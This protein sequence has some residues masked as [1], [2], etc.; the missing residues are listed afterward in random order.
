VQDG[1]IK[2][3]GKK[4]L[5]KTVIRTHKKL[6]IY[7]LAHALAV[8][9]HRLTL[10]LPRYQQFEEAGQ[11]R[12]SSKSVSSQIVEGHALRQYRNE[13]LRYLARSYASAEETMEHLTFAE[14]TAVESSIE[15][16]CGQIVAGYESL[17]HKLQ[18]YMDRQASR[19]T[20][21]K[22]SP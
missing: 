13:Y 14:E 15:A 9:V 3:S 21:K 18:N 10:N 6:K 5:D 11:M 1:T 12:R 7:Q 19:R 20:V 4:W 8:K 22:K 2:Q 17:C 16:E